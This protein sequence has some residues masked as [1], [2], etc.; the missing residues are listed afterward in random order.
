MEETGRQI[1]ETNAFRNTL[2]SYKT[3]SF[4]AGGSPSVNIRSN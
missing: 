3:A 1:G 2:R 4:R